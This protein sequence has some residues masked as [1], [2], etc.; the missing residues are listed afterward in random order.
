MLSFAAMWLQCHL[1]LMRGR[2]PTD[3]HRRVGWLELPPERLGATG[4]QG[5]IGR[6]GKT[7]CGPTL[8]N[9]IAEV[10]GVEIGLERA[11]NQPAAGTGRCD[12]NHL[13]GEGPRAAR[14]A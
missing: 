2:A 9:P 5:K 6:R 12:V 1:R 11:A 14:R 3:E 10:G 8:E 4:L 7:D 13:H